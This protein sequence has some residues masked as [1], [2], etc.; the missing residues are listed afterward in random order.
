VDPADGRT[1][2]PFFKPAW[3]PEYLLSTDYIGRAACHRR[4]RLSASGDG[5]P[6]GY[7]LNLRSTQGAKVRHLRMLSFDTSA[8]GSADPAGYSDDEA[9][10]SALTAH[11]AR[12]GKAGS[13]TVHPS[14]RGCYVT[15]LHRKQRPR[16]S[17]ILPTA[18]KIIEESGRRI[19]LVVN[20]VDHLRA[21]TDGDS[22][23]II[24]VDN[25]DL[26]KEQIAH[27]H[28]RGCRRISY[29]EPTFNVSK[30]LNLGASI[31]TG[32]LLL[33]INDD[34][35]VLTSDW[36]LRCVDLMD[37]PE[38]G[39]VGPRLLYPDGTIQHA[40]VVHNYGTPDHVRRGYPRADA[41]YFFSTCS[42]RNYL[43]V[44][45]ACMLTRRDL[46]RR[47]GGYTEDLAVS[48]NDIDHCLK[49]TEAG[50]RVVYAGS[51]ALTHMES[52]SR[53]AYADPGEL[54]YFHTRWS[55][56]VS[57]D[58]FYNERYLSIAPPT[59][60]PSTNARML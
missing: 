18:G 50:F 40:G 60:V 46:Y 3:S 42:N 10:L 2:T 29:F 47:V 52:K 7:D 37:D 26:S 8:A 15:V 43:A 4:S 57:V 55:E 13:V 36:L 33:L 20:L 24:V 1:S 41:G 5:L 22:L 49:A 32:D 44:T 54:Y 56:Q 19:D 27:L 51:V 23:E 17:V 30:K 6:V 16:I 53:I 45:G 48:F 58:P 12:Q 35:E 25:D 59:F 38:V 28:S 31:A 11:L 21:R 9:A 34:V 14:H 39:V